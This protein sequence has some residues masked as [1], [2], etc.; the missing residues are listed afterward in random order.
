MH[1]GDIVVSKPTDRPGG[2]VQYDYGKTI[3]D[4]KFQRAGTLN[5]PPA[6]LLTA[7]S[8]SESNHMIDLG[9]HRPVAL[10]TVL[11]KWNLAEKQGKLLEAVVLYSRALAGFKQKLGPDHLSTLQALFD[12]GN[13]LE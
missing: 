3:V 7:I 11:H 8:H 13:F 2:V 5:K 10:Q 9:S 4:G 1:L 12:S 6:V